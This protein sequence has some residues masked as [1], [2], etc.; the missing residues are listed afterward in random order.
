MIKIYVEKQQIIE[1][2]SVA[3]EI[4]PVKQINSILANVCLNVKDGNL[5]V[6]ST[7]L[8]I[9]FETTIKIEEG[10]DGTVLIL[11]D[12][13]LNI[14]KKL[15]NGTIII[16][17]IDESVIKISSST[18]ENIEYT[19]YITNDSYP[20]FTTA[21]MDGYSTVSQKEFRSM[22]HKTIFSVSQDEYRRNI[23]GIFLETTDDSVIMV[24]TDGR[25]LSYVKL[26]KKMNNAQID[27]SK[28][29]I[30]PVKVLAL[31]EKYAQEG[32]IGIQLIDEKT[33]FIHLHN[34]YFSSS[35][36][37]EEFPNYKRVIPEE[38]QYSIEIN[39][40]EL[41]TAIEQVALLSEKTRRI[42]LSI[43]EN[44]L[45]I[46][47]DQAEIGKAKIKIACVYSGPDTKIALNYSYILDPLRAIDEDE[48]VIIGFTENN[49]A[50]S[51]YSK[52]KEDEES[53]L[54]EIHVVMPMQLD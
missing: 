18:Q 30:I 51:L 12:K 1:A 20:E 13:L 48:D 26:S 29:I 44:T 22:I 8:S 15:P 9:G 7:N 32:Q 40:N 27:L 36:I 41:F 2:L 24:G 3:N 19:L 49:R 52:P 34:Y 54:T 46:N 33:L 25:R 38:Q 53:F 35:L 43:F 6:R 5:I 47:S 10:R 31:I 37:V 50:L 17:Q 28:G 45:I 42:T 39:K 4:V 23:S 14:V 11:C 16:D 21:P